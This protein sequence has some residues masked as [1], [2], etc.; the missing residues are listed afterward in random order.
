MLTRSKKD[1]SNVSIDDLSRDMLPE[2]EESHEILDYISEDT[3]VK[4]HKKIKKNMRR[5]KIQTPLLDLL[6]PALLSKAMNDGSPT[7]KRKRLKPNIDIVVDEGDDEDTEMNEESG[8]EL[9]VSDIESES[10]LDEMEYD[11]YDEQ[12]EQLLD[13]DCINTNGDGA[14]EYF[15]ELDVDKKKAYIEEMNKIQMINN[16]SVPLRFK[17]LNSKMDLQTKS[18]AMEQVTKLENMERSEGEYTKMDTW[19]NTLMKIPVGIYHQL[20][21]T[22]ES[23][24]KDKRDYLMNSSLVLDKAIY[25]HQEAKTHI[26]QLMSQW[27]KNPMANGNI[28]A[29]QGPMGNG[30]TTLVKEGIAKALGRP[31]AFIAL[32]GASDSSYFDGHCYTYEGARWGR[33]IDILIQSKC[34]NPVIYFDELDK[35]S[36]TYKGDEIIHLLTHLTDTSQNTLFQDN[37]FPGVYFDLSKV[38]FIF[39]FNDESKINKILKDRMYVINTKGFKKEEKIKICREYLLPQ[40][41]KEFNYGDSIEFTD[42][43]LGHTIDKYTSG[44]EGVRNL[45]RCLESMI[46]KINMYDILYNSDTKKTEVPLPFELEDFKLPYKVKNEDIDTLLKQKDDIYKPPEHMYL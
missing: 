10:D 11:E 3:V 7:K 41:L 23:T 31:F 27:I 38:L 2:E 44:E 1:L 24:D 20:R 36:E 35:V 26:L 29:I 42:D 28:L 4:E 32:G 33:I 40:I 13:L 39:S 45:K 9:S 21:I 18:V 37:Y 12:Y 34:M 8:S 15:H 17:I 43:V 14:I 5:G 19:I 22:N 46:S 16:S 6:L 30:K 25:G